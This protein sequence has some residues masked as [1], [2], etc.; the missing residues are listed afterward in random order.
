MNENIYLF[1]AYSLL[2]IIVML[3]ADFSYRFFKINAEWSRKIAHIGSGIVALTYPDY[4]HNHWVVFALSLSFTIILYASK[5]LRLFPSIFE[6]DRKSYGE[7]FFV[8]TSWLLFLL[9]QYTGE[10]IYFYLPFSIVVFADPMAALVG[11]SFPL[12][13]YKIFGNTKSIG[14]SLAFFV[15]SFALSYYFFSKT[16]FSGNVFLISL[17]HAAVLTFVEAISTKG[18]DNLTI[19]L[20]SVLFIYFIQ[21]I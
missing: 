13:K 12:K 19:P 11:K 7:L 20:V 2:L 21:H 17:V 6:V 16:A 3:V 14:G 5:K 18:T 4:I 8:W 9:Y 10:V 15:V 1:I